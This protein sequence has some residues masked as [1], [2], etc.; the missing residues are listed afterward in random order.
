M[1]GLL[2]VFQ[3]LLLQFYLHVLEMSYKGEE[4]NAGVVE[5]DRDRVKQKPGYRT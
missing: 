5:E 3:C 2:P 4:S 1:W